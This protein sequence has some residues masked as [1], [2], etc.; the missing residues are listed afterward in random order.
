[1]KWATLI[2]LL[3]CS[4]V[5]ESRHLQKRDT[6]HHSRV[7]GGIYATVGKTNFNHL[8]L[9]MLSQNFQK[10]SLEEHEKA[11]HE[12]STFAEHCVDH[13]EDEECKKPMI[14]IFH[15]KMC[16]HP[17]LAERYPWSVECCAKAE[18]E[19][20][21][22]FHDHRDVDEGPFQKP[23]AE[24]AC[25]QHK[26]DHD[27][28][29]HYYIE[30]IGKRHSNIYPPAV[31]AL[32]AQYD[33]LIT[34]CCQAEEKDKCFDAKF[35][36]LVKTTLYIEFKQK[37]VCH[38]LAHFPDR[39]YQAIKIAKISQKHPAA[40]FDLVHKYS[41]E[42]LHMSKDCCKGDVVECM[43]E[44]LEYTQHICDN[45]EKISPNLKVCCEKP[46]LERTPCIMAL[47]KDDIPADLPK[48]LPKEFVEDEHVCDQFKDHKDVHLAKF[49]HEFA[50]RHPELSLQALLRVGKGYEGLL[51]KC[52][53]SEN[54]VECYKAAP[55]LLAAGI[56][57]SQD[58]VKQ[59]CDA[60]EHLG[61]Y[62][63]NI[64]LLACYGKKFPQASDEALLHLTGKM[65][66]FG[67][68][69]CALPEN[70]RLACAEEK[71][72]LL[73]GEM[74]EKQ[75]AKFIN[76]QV[77]HCCDDSYADRR[78]CFT[79][80][81]VDPSYQP[82]AFDESAFKVGADICEGTEQEQQSKRLTL[83]IHV[84]KLKP[85]ISKEKLKETVEEFRTVREKC[86]AAPDH[87][88]C[89]DQERPTVLL[90]LKEV[91]GH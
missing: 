48:E 10:C 31:L 59:N 32:A 30:S 85:D 3:L 80:L 11:M 63:Y 29:L 56:K 90:H 2:C 40:T 25:K 89:F 81:G 35:P 45:H 91:L 36:D 57:E 23:D 66:K 38:I 5:A 47:P 62:G 24:S 71:L 46:V 4:I 13:E 7:I 50:K 16:K 41:D 44:R 37:H 14:T 51:T 79:K 34:E 67:G 6:D 58:L 61:P 33:T 15:D 53:A 9:V 27:H 64:M 68:K 52:C 42:S 55:Q 83:L 28:A 20:E 70:Q 75:S 26:E 8:L 87:Q 60:Y 72:D 54:P 49:L 77:R 82:P 12:L 1:M 86:C 21:K 69:C 74:C 43:I 88:V 17:E 76:D 39:V 65:T 84:L 73:L 22:C 78:P 19:R 18:P